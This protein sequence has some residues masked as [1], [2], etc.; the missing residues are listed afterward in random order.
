MGQEPGW[1]LNLDEEQ[2]ALDYHY[3]EHRFTAPT[4]ARTTAE[5]VTRYHAEQ[6]GEDLYVEI[7]RH[8]CED[9]MSGRPFPY[10]VEVTINGELFSGCGGDT[11]TL[12]VGPEWRVEELNGR[13]LS[14]QERS[15]T[16]TFDHD[17]RVS[18]N[19]GCN[20]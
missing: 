6:G 16:L 1:L 14:E 13:A 7:R 19:A 5:G 15:Q 8:Y 20:R 2:L 11:E 18:G 4:P 9:I 17:G 10:R 12:L 3:G